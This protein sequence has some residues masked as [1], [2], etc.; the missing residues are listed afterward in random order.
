MGPVWLTSALWMGLAFLASALAIW[1]G[2]SASLLEVAAGSLAAN[3][4][5]FASA[6]WV[7]YLAGLGA[8]LLAFL[9]G[10]EVKLQTIRN[11][12]FASLLIGAGAFAAPFLAVLLFTIFL[13]GWNWLKAL[14]GAIA[15]STT[16]VALVYAVILEE[17]MRESRAGQ[18]VLASR[19][20]N[21][22]FTV[23][24]LGVVA[25]NF[26]YRLGLFVGA[27]ALSLWI[28]PRSMPRILDWTQEQNLLSEP[29]VRMLG[30]I[31]FLLGGL[32]SISGRRR[33]F[34]P[35]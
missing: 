3:S 23:A 4:I 7:D 14:I 25:V 12:A 31:L 35:T 17:G 9:V 32:A 20:I 27:M 24:A 30:G 15:L 6:P 21:D 10:T 26:D 2:I 19:F 16:S 13:M 18:I 34:R 8:I 5:G 29:D 28:L 22:L 11:Y 33:L 1:T